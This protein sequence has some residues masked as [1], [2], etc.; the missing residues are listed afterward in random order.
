MEKQQ[1]D[2]HTVSHTPTA[3]KRTVRAIVS[4]AALTCA[5]AYLFSTSIHLG[6]PEI[7]NPINIGYK[8]G[9]FTW[10][11]C[12]DKYECSTLAVPIDYK[13]SS[14]AKFNLALIRLKATQ[15]A[16]K[17]PLF[18]NPGGPG[19][20]GVDLVL[21][22]GDILSKHVDGYYDIVGFDPRGVGASNTI[23]CFE[24]G[25]ESKF[26]L[27]N[28]NPY[29]SPG[30]NVANHA[31]WL[32]AQ[33]KQC[34]AKN[35]DFLPYVSTASVARDI[36]SL[37]D[38]FGQELTNYWGFSYGTFL[39]ATYVNM[40][41]DRVG[42]VILDGVTD[43]TTFS[44]EL[45]NWIKTSL[46]HTEDGLDEF[47]ATCEAAGPEKCA[48]ANRDKALAFDGQHYVAP[49]LR[50]YLNHLINNP[51]LFS[52]TS[53]QGVV[54]Q[55]H[56]ANALFASLYSVSSWPRVA[57]AFS[58]T[59]ETSTG[60]AFYNFVVEKENERCPLVEEYSLTA[61]PVLCIDGTH[62][63][64]PDLESYMKGLE[65]AMKVS[66]LAG[67]LWGT[68]MIQC[69]YWDVKP[70]E[71]FAGPWNHKTQ[72]KVLLIGATGDPVT[73][74][75][76]AAKLEDLMEGS[77][78]FHKHHGWGHCSL[79]QP[80]KCTTKVI[81]DYLVDGKVPE[82]GSECAMEDLPF[83]PT[84]SLQ[85]FGDSGLTSQDLSDLADAVHSAQRR[86]W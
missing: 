81:R 63:D 49:T 31:A 64:Q 13:N 16:S 59:I 57:K 76:S 44:G 86:M 65:E 21:R 77:G 33:A 10:K 24:D 61:M 40:F 23:R 67:R 78:V 17:G 27:A 28:R 36:D 3:P 39:G 7:S 6:N 26:F 54:L 50:Y 25:T 41:P 15:C 60:N 19:G 46:I 34:I 35:K 8:E 37:R 52:N 11:K 85:R 48:L 20:S 29:L 74:V 14:S 43:P 75:E 62:H 73:P 2:Q 22:A 42:R 82:K 51:L 47:G 53:T 70:S 38:A 68:A 18:V 30:D 12:Y 71:R 58:D 55:T 56:A 66:P 45:V 4:A 9:N 72:N 32:E 79:G 80:S 84:A 83:E 5:C 1:L 69:I